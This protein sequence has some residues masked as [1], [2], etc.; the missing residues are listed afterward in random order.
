MYNC[1]SMRVQIRV[2]VRIRV[3]IRVRVRVRD[4]VGSLYN[5]ASVVLEAFASIPAGRVRVRVRSLCLKPGSDVLGWNKG[6]AK[7]P[8]PNPH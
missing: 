6:Q 1:A 7:P 2:R 8:K 3:R 5:C 4:R